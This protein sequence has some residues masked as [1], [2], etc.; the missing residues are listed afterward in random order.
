M[1]GS[2]SPAEQHFNFNMSTDEEARCL[3]RVVRAMHDGNCPACGCLA[4][5]D[6]FYVTEIDPKLSLGRVKPEDV[7]RMHRCPNCKFTITQ[8]ESKAALAQF[9][10]IM[11]RNYEIFM[12]WRQRRLSAPRPMAPEVEATRENCMT[13]LYQDNK[14]APRTC[15]ACGL[16]P[17]KLGLQ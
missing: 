3:H 11:R 13:A 7:Q 8:E 12:A 6:Q 4:P 9:H 1:S 15:E 14:A 16:G 17:C 2:Q 10:G 5:S